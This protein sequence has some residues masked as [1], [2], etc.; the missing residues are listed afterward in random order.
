MQTIGQVS[1]G[2]GT[3]QNDS[4]KVWKSLTMIFNEEIAKLHKEGL[5]EEMQALQ[6]EHLASTRKMISKV[7]KKSTLG[8]FL[9]SRVSKLDEL[10]TGENLRDII[11][12]ILCHGSTENKGKMPKM[13][14]SVT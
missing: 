2:R 4:L 10:I 7:S 6:D 8:A 5:T 13:I 12:Y 9:D 14:T 3:P 1:V 11:S